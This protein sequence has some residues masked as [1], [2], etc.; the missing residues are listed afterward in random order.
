MTAFLVPNN[1]AFE[2]Y[3]SL[4]AFI[5]DWMDRADLEGSVES[6]VALTEAMMRR[7]LSPK[8]YETQASVSVTA[9][10]GALPDDCDFIRS[11]LAEGIPLHE[12]SPDS[13]RD[14]LTGATPAAYSQENDAIYVWPANDASV[15]ILYQRE[16]P[17]LS[18]AS[19]TSELL[20]QHPDLYF[21]GAMMF[22]EGYVANDTRAALFKS[23]W[24]EA[25]ASANRFFLRQRRKG[26][27]YGRPRVIV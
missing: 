12:V 10:V 1:L 15:D 14:Y 17:R 6:M 23:L 11:V 4:T 5:S 3:P 16:F 20:S 25:M 24:G 19:P 18:E 8:F 13:G 26:M 27:G 21:Y 2:D 7:E 9:G 22:A